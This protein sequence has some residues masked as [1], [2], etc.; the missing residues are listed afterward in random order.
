MMKLSVMQAAYYLQ[1]Q[2][3]YELPSEQKEG[4]R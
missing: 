1:F 2:L 3:V 4:A